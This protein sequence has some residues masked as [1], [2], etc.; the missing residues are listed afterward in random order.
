[1]NRAALL[2]SFLFFL[3]SY[4]NELIK[5]EFKSLKDG[6]KVSFFRDLNNEQKEEEILFFYTEFQKLLNKHEA[7]N[8]LKKQ[9]LFT[10]GLINQVQN[11][12]L[13]AISKFNELIKNSN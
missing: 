3:N 4:S 10:L 13:E 12:H 9:F 5:K 6:N 1:M 7:N 2:L 8:E 11:Q